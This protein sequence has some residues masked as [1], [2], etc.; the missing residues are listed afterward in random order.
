LQVYLVL[1]D[2][3]GFDGVRGVEFAQFLRGRR[4]QASAFANESA[5]AGEKSASERA[6]RKQGPGK[7]R[8]KREVQTGIGRMDSNGHTH[9]TSMGLP[10][11]HQRDRETEKYNRERK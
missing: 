10:R 7:D 8:P 9:T 11:Q 1:D 6:R 3:L 5:A 2:L 4:L